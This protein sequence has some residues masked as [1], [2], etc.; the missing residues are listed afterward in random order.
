MSKF[1]K[2][3]GG[4]SFSDT[5]ASQRPSQIPP[6]LSQDGLRRSRPPKGGRT[7]PVGVEVP[8]LGK[9]AEDAPSWMKRARRMVSALEK[10]IAEGEKN[11]VQ[12][13]AIDRAWSA[14]ELGGV[15]D[16]HIVLVSHLCERTHRAIRER[17]AG[18]AE[19]A[20]LACGEILYAGMPRSIRRNLE[21]GE[22]VGLVRNMRREAD[23]W[24]AVVAT[25]SVLLR[26]DH[27]ARSQA[28]HAIRVAVDASHLQK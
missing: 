27:R 4:I 3:L 11:P 24:A 2:T 23:S 26:W 17:F 25:T 19:A 1:Q 10:A 21:L 9:L 14:F 20:Y 16:E 15:S 12:L 28:A 18:P 5:P 8:D 6:P 22:V 13:A 7:P